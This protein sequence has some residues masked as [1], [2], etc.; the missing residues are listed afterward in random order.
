MLRGFSAWLLVVPLSGLGV[1]AGHELAYSLTRTPHEEVHGY[2]THAPQLAV[3]LTVLA[4]IGA[5][6]VERGSRIALWPFPA[7]ALSGF[8]LQEHLERIA[9]GGSVPF[10]LDKPFFL[11]GLA[12]QLV[13][14]VA[15]WLVAR[16]LVRVVGRSSAR[17]FRTIP[18]PQQLG[19]V[20]RTA[21]VGRCSAWALGPRAPPL[22]DR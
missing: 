10:L 19:S 8:V 22:F 13:V 11:V 18:R 21:L 3:M 5:V 2:L 6:F 7:L 9:H 17:R 14:A 1:I 16:L 4:I 12:L 15:A 20:L